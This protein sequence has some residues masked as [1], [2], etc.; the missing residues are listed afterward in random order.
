ML[1][2]DREHVDGRPGGGL[3]LGIEGAVTLAVHAVLVPPLHCDDSHCS[4]GTV[5]LA[6]WNGARGAA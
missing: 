4:P 3:N 2:S 1:T 6:Q 5:G